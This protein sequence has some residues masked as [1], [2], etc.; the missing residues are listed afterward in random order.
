MSEAERIEREGQGGLIE[1]L[2]TLIGL[3]APSARDEIEDALEEAS[4]DHVF[5]P[6]ERLILKNVLALHEVRVADVMLPRAD[7]T[8]IAADAP[9]SEV[10]ALFRTAGHSRLPVFGET[11]DDPQGMVHIRD[12]LD[13]LASEPRF[14]IA[15]EGGPSERRRLPAGVEVGMN[16]PLSAAAI[17]RPVLYAPPSMPA[18]DLLLK[19]QATRTHMALVIDEYGGTDG[20][21]SIEDVVEAIVGDIEDEHDQAERPKV[22]PGPDGSF[23]VEARAPL[24]EVSEAVGYDFSALRDAEDVDTIGGLVTSFAGRMPGRG[25][26]ISGLGDFEFEVLDADARRV[27]R[28]KIHVKKRPAGEETAAQG[29]LSGKSAQL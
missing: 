17:L 21:V 16:M 3:G 9:L 28:L 6:E 29:S 14:G 7:I 26:I 24:D 23:L 15:P 10:L 8:A 1:R 4:E 12:F 5:S 19:M 20:L 27:K 2:R 11:L 25:E 22:A 18:L 13:F